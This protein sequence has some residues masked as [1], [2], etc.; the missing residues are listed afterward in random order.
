[1]K[2]KKYMDRKQ[3]KT[4]RR[5]A[6]VLA[7][8]LMAVLI[9]P[10]SPSFAEKD[11]EPNAAVA[12]REAHKVKVGNKKYCFFVDHYVVFT[13]AEIES[14][15]PDDPDEESADGEDGD[16]EGGAAAGND[17]TAEEKDYSDLTMEILK[18]AGLYMK[19]ANCTDPKH[20]AITAEDWVKKGGS[21]RLYDEDIAS[22]LEAAPEDG[23]PVKIDMDLILYTKES[24]DKQPENGYTTFKTTGPRL[25]YIAIATEEDAKEGEDICKEEQKP[26]EKKKEKKIAK[27]KIKPIKTPSESEEMLPEYRTINMADRSGAP[28][29]DTLQ[30]GTPVTLEWVEPDKYDSEGGKSWIDRIPGRYAGLAVIA[31]AAAA[32]VAAIV[33][34]GKRRRKDES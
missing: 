21:F 10:A 24:A 16:A 18:R 29:E 23:K 2:E 19:E 28:V 34:I 27:K 20:K 32:A 6:A 14:L 3:N 1:M 11:G 33:V 31:A 12:L 25:L 17:E 5:L 13:R 22:I 26:A 8:L 30:D 15:V 4:G 9:V 7:A